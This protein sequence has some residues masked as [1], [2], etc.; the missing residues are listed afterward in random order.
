MKRLVAQTQWTV[1]DSNKL[2]DYKG[3]FIG[4]VVREM[5]SFTAE[6]LK[7]TNSAC[8]ECGAFGGEHREYFLKTGQCGAGSVEGYYKKCSIGAGK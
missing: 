2:Y 8:K 6:E 1:N 5:E 3:E 4:F 7:A